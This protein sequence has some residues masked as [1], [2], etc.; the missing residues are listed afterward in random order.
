MSDRKRL[1]QL[2]SLQESSLAGYA[3]IA[4]LQTVKAGGMKKQA[5]RNNMLTVNKSVTVKR[6]RQL[7]QSQNMPDKGKLPELSKAFRSNKFDSQPIA[8][9]NG[10]LSVPIKAKGNRNAQ[11]LVNK[12]VNFQNEKRTITLGE[13]PGDR[14][15]SPIINLKGI[16]KANET[17]R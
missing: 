7:R 5:S 1:A 3:P 6:D 12:S 14:N 13:S 10:D 8:N 17:L 15:V 2:M 11:R 9:N 16:G 4:S